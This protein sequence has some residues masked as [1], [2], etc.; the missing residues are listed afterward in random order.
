MLGEFYVIACWFAVYSILGWCTE[1]IY[2]AVNH[3]KY[4]NRG[5]LSGPVCPIYGVGVILVLLVLT[6]IRDKLF[7]LFIGSVLFTTLLEL[8]TG[9]ILE[10]VFSRKWW[11]YSKEPFHFKGYICLKF[12]LLWGIACVFVIHVVQ[13][14]LDKLISIIPMRFGIFL[15]MIFFSIF[16]FDL[17]ITILTMMNFKRRIKIIAHIEELL[18][19]ESDRIG[20][21]LS[22]GVNV[23]IK[24]TEKGKK[25]LVE[26]KEKRTEDLDELK[27]KYEKMIGKRT[28]GVERMIKAF[29]RLE[30][31]KNNEMFEK[32]KNYIKK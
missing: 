14:P 29:P 28:K 22:E 31:L 26:L 7:L 11:D 12:S 15:L 10:K 30:P 9:Y 21:N 18:K 23:L 2:Y 8:I 25:E 4:V 27:E 24:A 3:G 1:I 5:F 17:I 16:I 6:P 20:E 13:P 32:L 19:Q